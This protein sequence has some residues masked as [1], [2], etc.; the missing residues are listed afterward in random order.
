ML[1]SIDANRGDNQNGWDTDLIS[2]KYL[3]GYRSNVVFLQS[4]GLQG[5]E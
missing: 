4:G 5:E 3:G 2:Y 1:G